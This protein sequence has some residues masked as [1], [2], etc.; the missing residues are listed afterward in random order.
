MS[1][2]TKIHLPHLGRDKKERNPC[3][4]LFNLHPQVRPVL[5]APVSRAGCLESSGANPDTPSHWHLGCRVSNL[6]SLARPL[7]WVVMPETVSSKGRTR[8]WK[9]N[10]GKDARHK[11]YLLENTTACSLRGDSEQLGAREIAA[12]HFHPDK[13]LAG[14]LC[15]AR[16]AAPTG[17]VVKTAQARGY[18]PGSVN[19]LARQTGRAFRIILLGS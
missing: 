4:L 7:S 17:E 6:C 10:G 18:Q 2:G 3:Q 9:V 8:K 1:L 15:C 14:H 5:H 16:H 13:P 11:L 19:R 12:C